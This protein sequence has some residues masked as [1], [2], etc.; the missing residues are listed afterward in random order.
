[1][2]RV[3]EAE[4]G[5]SAQIADIMARVKAIKDEMLRLEV[6]MSGVGEV[7][8]RRL[9]SAIKVQS[10]ELNVLSDFVVGASA[11]A[12][13]VYIGLAEDHEKPE[14]EGM[15]RLCKEIEVIA[16]DLLCYSLGH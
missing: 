4:M 6:E 7:E 11:R 14:L 8:R 13:A 5:L 15:R 10:D 16:A 3:E 12:W 2:S 9:Q 1:M